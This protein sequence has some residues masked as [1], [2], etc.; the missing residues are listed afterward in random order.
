MLTPISTSVTA[1]GVGWD[2]AEAVAVHVLA[3]SDGDGMSDDYETLHG[4]NLAADDSDADADGDGVTNIDE[5]LVGTSAS[6]A[7]DPP[8]AP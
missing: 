5:F 4:P 6:D 7:G 8:L 2:S 1:S 3:D